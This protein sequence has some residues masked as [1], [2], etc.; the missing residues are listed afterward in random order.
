MRYFTAAPL[1]LKT[2]HIS[3]SLDA[4]SNTKFSD[5]I[6][7]YVTDILYLKIILFSLL[8]HVFQLLPVNGQVPNKRPALFN[9]HL[10]KSKK[11]EIFKICHHWKR[12]PQ[13]AAC[14]ACAAVPTLL[15][16]SQTF[17]QTGDGNIRAYER[18][19]QR[20]SR[21]NCSELQ[22]ERNVNLLLYFPND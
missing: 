5:S 10:T 9:F 1:N 22:Y 18:M 6:I 3:Y 21:I 20:I 11:K 2:D 12:V 4:I 13:G 8:K 7:K 17:F 16:S 14:F 15:P 19:V